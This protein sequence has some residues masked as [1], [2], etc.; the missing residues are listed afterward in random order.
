MLSG[1]Q[2]FLL[3]VVHIISICYINV[4]ASIYCVLTCAGGVLSVLHTTLWRH[5][6]Y[7]TAG[8]EEGQRPLPE[9][10]P[11]GTN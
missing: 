7:F 5:T 9:G 1:Y 8:D 6:Y 2:T 10:C 4:M 11:D 3:T